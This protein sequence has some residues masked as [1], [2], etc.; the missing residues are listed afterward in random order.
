MTHYVPGTEI[1]GTRGNW[2]IAR[3]GA[4]Q[5]R[6]VVM[7][8]LLHYPSGGVSRTIVGDI[9][10]NIVSRKQGVPLVRQ[11]PGA[12][13]NAWAAV[14]KDAKHRAEELIRLGDEATGDLCVSHT[15]RAAWSLRRDQSGS[16]TPCRQTRRDRCKRHCGFAEARERQQ[17]N[18]ESIRPIENLNTF[19]APHL[20]K[21]D[22]GLGRSGGDTVTGWG[23]PAV[24]AE[25]P[26][27]SF[28]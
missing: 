22:T 3:V 11:S 28:V 18:H 13:R 24:R 5:N 27:V 23:S 9:S 10:A 26:G 8:L 16:R 14:T 1:G 17:D 19:P 15:R 25:P 12:G 21:P 4:Q 7:F 20:R 2:P 6:Q